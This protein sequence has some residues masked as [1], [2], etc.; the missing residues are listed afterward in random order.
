MAKASEAAKA[1]G[2]G[3]RSG[4][5]YDELM[6][7]AGDDSRKQE[8]AKEVA[9]SAKKALENAPGAMTSKMLDEVV[10]NYKKAANYDAYSAWRG[11]ATNIAKDTQDQLK[12]ILGVIEKGYGQ[13]GM[14]DE[15]DV[16]AFREAANV[17]VSAPSK[18]DY[19]LDAAI[20][21]FSNPNIQRQVDRG[22]AA[23]ERSATARGMNDSSDL[24]KMISDYAAEKASEDYQKA[25]ALA[26]Q[27][28]QTALS[29]WLSENQ[30]QQNADT[31]RLTGLSQLAGFGNSNVVGQTGLEVGATQGAF[32]TQ[33]TAYLSA[34]AQQLAQQEAEKARKAAAEQADKDF[35]S[36]IIGTAGKIAGA[37]LTKTPTAPTA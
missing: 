8:Y 2:Y 30:L 25:A 13:E 35:F 16:Q 33:N 24:R 3:K 19:D 36:T 32:D 27:D 29:Q 1:A 10:K 20:E 37:A 34:K 23:I 12:Q 6:T 22:V 4:K 9:D 7:W 5:V 11:S 17:G 18:F 26:N 14:A 28:K 21:R 15:A 31:S